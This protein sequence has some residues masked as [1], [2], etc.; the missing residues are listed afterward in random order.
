MNRTA[1]P[2]E[3]SSRHLNSARA[4]VLRSLTALDHVAMME[5][6]V[7]ALQAAGLEHGARKVGDAARDVR[8]RDAHGRAVRLSD[9]WHTGPLVVVFYRGG[10]CPYGNEHLRAWQNQIDAVR[11]LGG[12]VVAISPDAAVGGP[13]MANQDALAFPVMSDPALEAAGAFGVAYTVAPELVDLYTAVNGEVP[14]VNGSGQWVLPVAA[15]F[16]IDETGQIRFARVDAGDRKRA[17]AVDVT[18]VIE[19]I[20]AM[21]AVA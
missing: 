21:A 1:T 5:G 17:E 2:L 9:L 8:V 14:V 15:T 11:S 7:G 6:A 4:G 3:Q 12:N 20:G 18:E 16:V 10:W 13:G 19:A